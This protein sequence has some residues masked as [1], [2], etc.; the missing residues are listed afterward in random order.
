MFL[1]Y[2]IGQKGQ[3]PA[4]IFMKEE[5]AHNWGALR[6]RNRG[7]YK[8]ERLRKIPLGRYSTGEAEFINTRFND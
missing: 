2:I 6:S 4:A 5:D 8:I 3:Q 7:G 1:V